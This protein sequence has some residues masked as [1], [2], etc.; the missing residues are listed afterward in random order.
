MIMK[1]TKTKYYVIS[2][3]NNSA[4][5]VLRQ[6]LWTKK[7]VGRLM[8]SYRTRQ[9]AEKAMYECIK[10]SETQKER[11]KT[12]KCLDAIANVGYFVS[13]HFLVG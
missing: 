5:P 12:Y 6:T 8:Y 9:S 2:V 4:F 11:A 13:K 3:E 10:Y 1:E 7:G